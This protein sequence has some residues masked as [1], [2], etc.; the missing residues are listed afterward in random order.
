MRQYYFFLGLHLT[1]KNNADVLPLCK[2]ATTLW[3]VLMSFGF[4]LRS[5]IL[6][7]KIPVATVLHR[8]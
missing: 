2:L 8:P 7:Q 4:D 5:L 6:S 1:M 3:P